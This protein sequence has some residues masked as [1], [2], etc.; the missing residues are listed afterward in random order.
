[1]AEEPAA[2]AP[3]PLAPPD[4]PAGFG[5]DPKA[6]NADPE[7]GV[8]AAPPKPL[9]PKADP[10]ADGAEDPNAEVEPNA[11]AAAAEPKA[12]APKAEGVL[13]AVPP[14]PN[15]EPP[16]ADFGA[17]PPA[18]NALGAEDPDPAPPEKAPNPPPPAAGVAEPNAVAG[19]LATPPEAPK[20]DPVEA[21]PPE[22]NAEAVPPEPNAEG[23]LAAWPK[24]PKPPEL[25]AGVPN[26]VVE[27]PEAVP[28][29]PK[30]EG[31][32]AEPA[33]PKTPIAGF[34]GVAV[35]APKGLAVEE[36]EGDGAEAGEDWE[37]ANWNAW[38]RLLRAFWTAAS[39]FCDSSCSGCRSV[40]SVSPCETGKWNFL[41]IMRHCPLP[42]RG[43]SGP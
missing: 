42:W 1:M 14:E 26:G 10:L 12:G 9:C 43:R 36:A 29:P 37:R 7:A 5:A 34:W 20:A 32:D 27:E 30:A 11:G 31:A 22:P 18:P 4:V 8:D 15:A 40:A 39:A 23:L 25:G 3:N 19:L 16:N 13:V 2:K 24:A 21:V 17:D 33:A 41:R 38:S 35:A 6:P 28:A